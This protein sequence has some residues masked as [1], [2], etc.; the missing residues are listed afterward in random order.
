MTGPFIRVTQADNGAILW[1][2]AAHLVAV[3]DGSPDGA[4]LIFDVP[5]SAGS[6]ILLNV[7]E[8]AQEIARQASQTAR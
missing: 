5:Y 3:F 6:S 4:R 2:N 1:V 8:S 7:N